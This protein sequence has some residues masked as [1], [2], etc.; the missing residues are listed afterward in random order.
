MF[1]PSSLV[2]ALLSLVLVS[3]TALAEKPAKTKNVEKYADEY[4]GR[5]NQKNIRMAVASKAFSWLSGSPADNEKL[6]VGK[7]AQFF[8]FVALRY[9]SDRAARRGDLGRVFHHL[10]SE[11]QRAAV[12]K[13]AKQETQ[14]MQDWWTVRKQILRQLEYHLY[15]G[16]AINETELLTLSAEFGWL[17]AHA[18]LIEAQACASIEQHLTAAQWQKLKQ[19][20]K[21][22]A[23]ASRDNKARLD[24]SSEL[25]QNIPDN[26]KDLAARYEDI[27]AKCFSYLT[28]TLQD[29]EVIPLGQPAQF[30][31]FVSIRHKSGRG[32]KRGKIS[33]QFDKLLSRE[34]L[35]YLN[36]ATNALL[37]EIKQFKRLRRELMLYMDRVR[38]GNQQTFDLEEYKQL[39]Y[40]L[41][42]VEI[43]C[44]IIEA[45]SYRKVRAVM[46]EAQQAQMMVLRSDYIIDSKTTENLA[47]LDRGKQLFKLCAGC[48]QQNNLAPSLNGILNRPVASLNF[49]YSDAFKQ[50][51]SAIWT[52]EKLDSFLAAPDKAIPGNKMGFA[53][54]LKAQDRQAL[55]SYLSTLK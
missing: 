16:E 10:A 38:F 37:L 29:R 44:A 42:V 25:E 26:S 30:F 41:G 2:I 12:L 6:S 21:D 50:Q 1:K 5:H 11:Q 49:A 47:G 55:I 43:R 24:F 19:L 18:G 53:G 39:A 32:A 8:G 3:G 28:G 46:S 51:Q 14:V 23:L 20:R 7:S 15:T 13:A 27:F 48:H 17:N 4:S 22:P 9:Q 54:L 45:L 34:Q 33:K 52:S 31:G 40:K 35:T 36:K